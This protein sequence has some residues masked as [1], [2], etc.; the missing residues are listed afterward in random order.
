[1][2]AL[3]VGRAEFRA[4]TRGAPTLLGSAALDTA[5]AAVLHRADL[6]SR[7]AGLPYGRGKAANLEKQVASLLS[8]SD[9]L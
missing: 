1:V 5:G 2:P 4:P 8:G 7:R 9:I 3:R 6:F